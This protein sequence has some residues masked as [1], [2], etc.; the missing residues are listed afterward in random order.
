LFVD[1]HVA[2]LSA[3]ARAGRVGETY[4]V[5]GR[6][7]RRNVDVAREILAHVHELAPGGSQSEIQFVQDRPGHDRRYAIDC[8]KI[9]TELGW[10]A[11]E[12]FESGLRRTV[13][14]YVARRDWWAPILKARYGG[15]R[16]GLA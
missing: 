13:E 1:D 14:W 5:G 8:T 16:L 7:E 10:R 15:E 3:I 12:T 11:A 2:A 9:E 4:N 6:S